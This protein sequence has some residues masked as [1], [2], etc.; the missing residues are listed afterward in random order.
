MS[1]QGQ[2]YIAFL[3]LIFRFAFLCRKLFGR[4]L[5]TAFIVL[6]SALTI[7]SFVYAII[8]QLTD[9]ATAYYNN[10]RGPGD[11][12]VRLSGH[13]SHSIGGRCGF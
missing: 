10:R 7:A 5:R 12:S 9:Q 13:W 3:A 4:H 1:V 8:A 2:F 6:L 11:C